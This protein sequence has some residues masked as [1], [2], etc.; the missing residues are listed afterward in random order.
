[1]SKAKSYTEFTLVNFLEVVQPQVQ[2][3][4]PN[5][6]AFPGGMPPQFGNGPIGGAY[7]GPGLG[8]QPVAAYARALHQPGSVEQV[9]SR[10][11]QLR[12]HIEEKENDK[13]REDNNLTVRIT[14]I[15]ISQVWLHN[16]RVQGIESVESKWVG[17]TKT[18]TVVSSGM[19]VLALVIQRGH[20]GAQLTMVELAAHAR[21]FTIEIS[22][23]WAIVDSRIPAPK[24][25]ARPRTVRQTN[26]DK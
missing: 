21:D 23:E 15:S 13:L 1:M 3:Q 4:N 10:S 9:L 2:Y 5:M 12:P 14:E 18:I 26:K 22:H 20:Y 19:P 16:Q 7:A 24:R 17:D 6:Q 8:Y 25:P 11:I